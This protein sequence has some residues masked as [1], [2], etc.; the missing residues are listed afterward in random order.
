MMIE[1][2]L[3]DRINRKILIETRIITKFGLI[4]KYHKNK[5]VTVHFGFFKA[6][7]E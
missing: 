7:K 6:P 2:Q 4:Y 5:R 1:K 3:L